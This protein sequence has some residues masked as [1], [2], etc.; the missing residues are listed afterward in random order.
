MRSIHPARTVK[1]TD[2]AGAWMDDADLV[3]VRTQA[4][5][6]STG[7]FDR[8][9]TMALV[10]RGGSS[11]PARP[12]GALSL[13][14]PHPAEFDEPALWSNVGLAARRGPRRWSLVAPPAPGL[15]DPA[16]R[17][18]RDA[19]RHPGRLLRQRPERL[20]HVL[21]PLDRRL[22]VLLLRP[23][24]GHGARGR[25]RRRLRLGD[26]PAPDSTPVVR[27]MVTIGSI[28]GR[29]PAGGRPGR[30]AA[31]ETRGFRDP[32]REPGGGRRG[33]PRSSRPR[34]TRG[35][36]A[37]RSARRRSRRRAPRPPSS[38]AR[39]PPATRC[40][41]TAVAGA[42]T[43]RA[44]LPFVTPGSG[45]VQAFTSAP[46]PLRHAR[47]R[48][49]R[50]RSS[51]R[52]STV[53]SA[54][55]QPVLKDE[56]AAVGVLAVYW[57]DHLG[58]AARRDR[59]ARSACSALEA[60]IAI[61][62]GELLGTARGGG[63]HRRPHRPAQPA[64]LGRGAGPRAGARRARRRSPLRRDPRSRPLQA[65]QRRP[66]P[67]R[68][69]PLPEADGGLL[70]RG[71]PRQRHPRPLRRRGVRAR[72]ARHRR[73]R[74]PRRCS[75]AL[76]KV[77][78]EGQTCSAGVCLWDGEESAEALIARADTA[79]YAAKDAGPRPRHRPPPQPRSS[80]SAPSGFK[81]SAMIPNGSP[82]NQMQTATVVLRRTRRGSRAAKKSTGESDI[83]TPKR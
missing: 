58:A 59:A 22:R 72:A 23:A 8:P 66:R 29:R 4:D 36:W 52:G 38:G 49:M 60:A 16:V 71:A 47:R 19:R 75:S 39:T 5:S 78:P 17:P 46:S 25:D 37:G 51:R 32:R 74:T 2:A 41:A 55:W 54:L 81:R 69:G 9:G 45:A 27:W 33:R 21:V 6:P 80:S 34:A 53:G 1:S 56:G 83:I 12:I 61:E 13:V 3:E 64:R 24:L 35:R 63:P 15:G 26:H 68:R 70:E 82:R 48:L 76:R 10:A 11:S 20:L 67:P 14:L 73:S 43:E 77:L 62:R 50:R 79:L 28:A 57:E 65:V 31:Q 7:L 42:G 30:P 44:R 18:R 40:V